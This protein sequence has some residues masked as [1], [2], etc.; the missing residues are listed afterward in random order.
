[1]EPLLK[2][3]IRRKKEKAKTNKTF[4]IILHDQINFNDLIYY[5]MLSVE[6][7]SEKGSQKF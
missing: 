3:E 4:I 1:M 5:I 2:K 6:F 7:Y